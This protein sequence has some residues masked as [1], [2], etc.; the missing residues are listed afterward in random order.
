MHEPAQIFCAY[1]KNGR[2]ER[3]L[4]ARAKARRRRIKRTS[5]RLLPNVARRNVAS[6][7][8]RIR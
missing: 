2:Q 1:K 8:V 3:A 6:R 5:R 7:G 4:R